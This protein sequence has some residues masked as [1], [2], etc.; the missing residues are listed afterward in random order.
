M[1]YQNLCLPKRLAHPEG[2][3]NESIAH[4]K[5]SRREYK[6]KILLKL[7]YKEFL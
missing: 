7:S 1:N 5:Y 4:Y 6:D 3:L 2:H